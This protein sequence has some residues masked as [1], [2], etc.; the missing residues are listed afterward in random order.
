MGGTEWAEAPPP[1]PPLGGRG[2]ETALKGKLALFGTCQVPGAT[3][4]RV[5]NFL[6]TSEKAR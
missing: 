1:V 2:Q 3:G 6:L 5:R 4:N